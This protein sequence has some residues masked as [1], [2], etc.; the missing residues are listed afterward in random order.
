MIRYFCDNC[1]KELT[2][3]EALH[4]YFHSKSLARNGNSNYYVMIGNIKNACGNPIILCEDCIRKII[5]G[6]L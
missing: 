2:K 6:E 4:P 1:K 3:D 5:I